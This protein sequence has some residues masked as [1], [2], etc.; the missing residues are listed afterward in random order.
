MPHLRATSAWPPAVA[1]MRARVIRPLRALAAC[2]AYRFLQLAERERNVAQNLLIVALKSRC[3][4]GQSTAHNNATATAAAA[5]QVEVKRVVGLRG[6]EDKPQHTEA[7]RRDGASL[8]REPGA[9]SAR[10]RCL[11]I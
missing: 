2:R 4:C 9:R 3:D 11:T 1:M 8:K 5:D 10:A 7:A 6:D